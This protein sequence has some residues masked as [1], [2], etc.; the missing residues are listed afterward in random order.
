MAVLMCAQYASR[1]ADFQIAHGNLKARAELGKLTN[2]LQAALG[3]IGQLLAPAK[4]KVRA[5][6]AGRTPDTTANLVQLGKPHAVSVFDDKRIAVGHIHAGFDNRGTDQDIDFPFQQL[7]PDGADFL[8]VH[9]AV[10]NTDTRAGHQ[11]LDGGSF[12]FDIIDT[13][14]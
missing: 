10:R 6:A 4:S 14:V 2:G 3:D 5:G 11:F 8:F 13:I 9:S 7:L 1:A 12:F